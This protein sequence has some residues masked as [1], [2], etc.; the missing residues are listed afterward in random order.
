LLVAQSGEEGADARAEEMLRTLP[1]AYPDGDM[2]TE[3]LFRAALERMRRGDWEGARPHLARIVDIA[4]DDRHWAVAGRATYFLARADAKKGDAQAARAR[5]VEIVQKYPLAFYMLLAHARLASEDPALAKR[6]LDDAVQR[7]AKDT[8]LGGRGGVDGD[9][10]A[11]RVE[12]AASAVLASP[13]LLRAARLLE[14][15]ELDAAKREIAASGANDAG[16]DADV[17]WEVGALYNQVGL[18]DIGHA[19][20]RKPHAMFAHYPEGRWRLAWETAYPRAFQPLVVKAC[21]ERGLPTPVAWAIMRE[22][23]SFVPEAKSPSNAFGLMQLI[24][25]TAQWV[26]KGTNLAVDEGQLKRPEVSIALGVKLLASLRAKHG[27]P[28]LAVGAYNGGSGAVDRWSAAR[29][30]DE[31][32]LF[33]EL[34]PW[35][36]TRN[37]VKRVLSTQAAYAYLYDPGALA[38]PLGL[39]LGLAR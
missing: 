19:F 27:H 28:A 7:D 21:G 26:A 31:L 10:G 22:E 23:S 35:E 15:G 38:E 36:E 24:L 25:P 32:D 37:Y 11:R 3:A 14:V 12:A 30:T 9:G 18:F 16:V 29:T 4:P 1:D 2:R 6:T 34:V 5:Y 13:A 33:V 8:Q 39:P 20:A 17:A